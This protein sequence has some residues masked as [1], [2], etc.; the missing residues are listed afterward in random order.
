[1]PPHTANLKIATA[2]EIKA[3]K[4]NASAVA[5]N[6]DGHTNLNVLYKTEFNIT[7]SAAVPKYGS[8]KVFYD[9]KY[10]QL[11]GSAIQDN[12]IVWTF[13]ATDM[14]DTQ[15]MVT[16]YGGI[17]GFIMEQVYDVKIFVL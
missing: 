17:D 8:C 7:A 11:Q 9:T 3:I 5:E 10:L 15:V 13:L 4:Q 1:M 16:T 12:Q 14:G 2:N 6:T